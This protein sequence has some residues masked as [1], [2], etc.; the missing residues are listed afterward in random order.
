MVQHRSSINDRS[1]DS[2]SRR[3]QI[4]LISHD[5]DIGVNRYQLSPLDQ[6]LQPI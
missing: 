5:S 4:R 3:R 6:K 1:I 2:P